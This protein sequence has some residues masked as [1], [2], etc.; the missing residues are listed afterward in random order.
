M[1]LLALQQMNPL[2]AIAV[3]VLSIAVIAIFGNLGKRAQ[4]FYWGY[5]LVLLFIGGLLAA[6]VIF[7]ALSGAPNVG[8]LVGS[9]RLQLVESE[10][11]Q[12]EILERIPAKLDKNQ[13]KTV[14]SLGQAAVVA[15]GNLNFKITQ[16]FW[17]GDGG[18]TE[19]LMAALK[20]QGQ[21]PHSVETFYD[22]FV[23]VIEAKAA[24]TLAKTQSAVQALNDPL[25][26]YE[27]DTAW[28]ADIL[29]QPTLTWQQLG[30][31]DYQ[32]PIKIVSSNPVTS[33][34]GQLSLMLFAYFWDR[35]VTGTPGIDVPL[36]PEVAQKIEGFTQGVA[37]QRSSG[38]ILNELTRRSYTPWAITYQSTAL[39]EKDKW[40]DR[41]VLAKLTPTIVSSNVM[42]G[43]G[44]VGLTLVQQLK[45]ENSPLH[46]GMLS[47]GKQFNYLATA[48]S[49]TITPPSRKQLLAVQTATG[50]CQADGGEYPCP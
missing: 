13:L 21:N 3:A 14:G 2:S 49:T 45:I 16:L 37:R 25:F 6:I 32:E 17:S 41:F 11:F 36:N 38:E 12:T 4:F 19:S 27:I 40:Q 50:L 1:A 35:E 33:G 9:E 28:M 48:P 22:P 47:V 15:E 34:G 43:I 31:S 7:Q 10:A 30:L 39:T 29:A 46:E 26:A 18:Q 23:V 5:G 44:D 20:A 24:E 42:V 8:M